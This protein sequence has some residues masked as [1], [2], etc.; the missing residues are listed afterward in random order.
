MTRE[1]TIRA[2]ESIFLENK[3]QEKKDGLLVASE[4]DISILGEWTVL[5][6]CQPN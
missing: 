2:K 1:G 4:P 3:Y 5:N 6:S